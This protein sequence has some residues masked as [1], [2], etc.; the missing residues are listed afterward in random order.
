MLVTNAEKTLIDLLRDEGQ[1][2]GSLEPSHAWTAFRRF[3]KL[4][5]VGVEEHAM[6]YEYITATVGGPGVSFSPCAA[7][8]A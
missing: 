6:L 4:P 2:P 3:M 8:S 5:V 7:S 1:E